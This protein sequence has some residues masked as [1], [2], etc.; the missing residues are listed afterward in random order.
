MVARARI[1]FANSRIFR[2]NF[3]FFFSEKYECYIDFHRDF[4][5]RRIVPPLFVD[6]FAEKKEDE[7]E[8]SRLLNLMKYLFPP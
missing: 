7:N 8:Y 4:F 3:F 1:F 6:F 2:F 5:N